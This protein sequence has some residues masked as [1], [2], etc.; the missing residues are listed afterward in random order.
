MPTEDVDAL[1]TTWLENA[2]EDASAWIDS[3]LRKRYAA[4]FSSPY[5]RAVLRWVADIVTEQAYLRRGAN[6]LD[7]QQQ[8]I[9]AAAERARTEIKEAADG[10]EGLFD[11]P[12]RSDTTATGIS[13]G[14]PRSYSEQS[15]YVWMNA[16]HSTGRDEDSNGGGSYG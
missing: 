1:G 12:L 14:G 7:A 10:N 3:R 11:L 9:A 8:Q 6:P 5:P 15:P 4:P 2:L 16:Q 13:K